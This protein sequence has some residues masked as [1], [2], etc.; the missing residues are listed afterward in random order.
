MSV[1]EGHDVKSKTKQT[2]RGT[3]H[4]CV[5]KCKNKKKEEKESID[6]LKL[7]VKQMRTKRVFLTQTGRINGLKQ[8][9]L[10]RDF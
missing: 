3:Q 9:S 4:I 10:V 8:I 5:I 6:D 2:C 1:T 7:D